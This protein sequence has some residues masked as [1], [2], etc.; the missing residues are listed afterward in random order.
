MKEILRIGM[1]GMEEGDASLVADAGGYIVGF[2]LWRCINSPFDLVKK[3]AVGFMTYVCVG[4]RRMGVSLMLRKA[5]AERV[6]AMGFDGV[7]GV[8]YH[9][10]GLKASEMAG[11]IHRGTLVEL[12]C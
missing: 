5:G 12:S 4:Y 6:R 10:S 7:Q 3:I 8:A 2:L 11:F 9:E 1:E